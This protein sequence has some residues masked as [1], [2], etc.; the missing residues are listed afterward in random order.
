VIGSLQTGRINDSKNRN[1][2]LRPRKTVFFK[3]DELL[4]EVLVTQNTN[5]YY[6]MAKM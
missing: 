6:R 4:H 2:K 5:E 3:S 1:Q